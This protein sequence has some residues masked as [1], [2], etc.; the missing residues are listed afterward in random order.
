[1]LKLLVG[2][3]LR[4]VDNGGVETVLTLAFVAQFAMYALPVNGLDAIRVL[5]PD[6]RDIVE[7]GTVLQMPATPSTT[8][9][10]RSVSRESK[11]AARANAA[12]AKTRVRRPDPVEDDPGV[13]ELDESRGAESTVRI[14]IIGPDG[15]P[16][17]KVVRVSGSREGMS[18]PA[19]RPHD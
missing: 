12:T 8:R 10:P 14:T 6:E 11:G 2:K 4:V 3:V 5:L 17:T 16:R 15:E 19:R 18:A 1:M 7:T 13:E 9:A